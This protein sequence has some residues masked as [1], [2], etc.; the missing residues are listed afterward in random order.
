MIETVSLGGRPVLC[1]RVIGV[2]DPFTTWP[3]DLLAYRQEWDPFIAAHVAIWRHLNDLFEGTEAGKQCPPGVD[4]N[5]LQKLDPTTQSFCASLILTRMRIDES[6][7]GY[8]I[9][10]Q[11]NAWRD[12]PA[13]EILAGA[14]AI[15]KWHQ[16]VVARVAGAYK[17]ELLKIAQIWNLNVEL[18]S[19][20][21]FTT[22]Q[23]IIGAIEGAYV[24]AKGVLQIAGYAA[25]TTL[26]W[27]GSQSQALVE[28]LTDTVKAVPKALSSSWTWVGMAAVLALVGGALVVYY[29][30]HR[31]ADVA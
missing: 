7:A 15:L 8:G 23:A 11:W 20:P 16:D 1:G 3:S 10:A 4:P 18:P 21:T 9:P 5:L 28:G 13:S 25:G 31:K 19:V 29:V 26:Q 17:D 27:A 2:G 14:G 24:T 6:N 22:Q 12:T 30:P